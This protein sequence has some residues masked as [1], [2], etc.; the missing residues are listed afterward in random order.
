MKRFYL[1][2]LLRIVGIA[3]IAVPA[4]M[5]VNLALVL[6]RAGISSIADTGVVFVI[7]LAGAIIF[8]IALPFSIVAGFFLHLILRHFSLPKLATL[9]LFILAGSVVNLIVAPGEWA[10]YGPLSLSIVCIAW[11]LYSWGPFRLWRFEFVEGEHSDF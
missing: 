4:G 9:P 10:R 5:V 11:L 2:E 8:V 3:L 7:M 6:L 1:E